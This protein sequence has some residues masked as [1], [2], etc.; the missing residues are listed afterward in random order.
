MGEKNTSV[1]KN[2]FPAQFGLQTFTESPLDAEE[3][4]TS[5]SHLRPQLAKIHLLTLLIHA[6]FLR[7]SHS[8]L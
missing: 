8:S 6:T 5:L 7:F 1:P 2:L 3:H 4:L